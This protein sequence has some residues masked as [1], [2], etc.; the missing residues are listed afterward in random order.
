M[1]EDNWGSGG[2]SEIDG[3]VLNDTGLNASDVSAIVENYNIAVK[4]AQSAL[5]SKHAYNW[6]LVRAG[7]GVA[8][9][10]RAG[11]VCRGWGGGW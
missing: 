1:C 9:S 10:S 7:S 8:V 6:Q 3:H 2:P 5:L 11:Y 4:A